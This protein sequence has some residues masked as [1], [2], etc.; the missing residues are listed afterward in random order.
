MDRT[1]SPSRE[2]KPSKESNSPFG[3]LRTLARLSKLNSPYKAP[4]SAFLAPSVLQDC[5]TV[6][7]LRLL[8]FVSG[9]IQIGHLHLLVTTPRGVW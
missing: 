6:L 5:H 8:F 4:L 7:L 2:S 1:D 9:T 3:R